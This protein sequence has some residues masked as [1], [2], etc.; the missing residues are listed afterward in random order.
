MSKKHDVVCKNCGS[1]EIHVDC[2]AQW[3]VENQEFEVVEAYEKG[4]YCPSCDSQ[5]ARWEMV[6]VENEVQ[7]VAEGGSIR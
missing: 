5:D 6:E 2:Y 4:G 3:S 7:T 1:D